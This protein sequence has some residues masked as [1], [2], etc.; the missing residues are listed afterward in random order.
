MRLDL[1]K[2]ILLSVLLNLLLLVLYYLFQSLYF[3]FLS[4]NQID[5][6][7]AINNHICGLFR[8]GTS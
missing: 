1:L 5:I 2:L 6:V 7:V 4:L 8:G 3:F